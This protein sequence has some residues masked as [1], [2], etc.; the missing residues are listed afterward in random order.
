[1]MAAMVAMVGVV[2]LTGLVWGVMMRA[3]RNNERGWNAGM[4]EFVTLYAE[5]QQCQGGTLQDHAA[6][7]AQR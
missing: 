1:M 4:S 7:Y 5:G 2:D 3:H 6:A